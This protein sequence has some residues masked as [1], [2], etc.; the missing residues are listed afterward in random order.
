MGHM[1]LRKW[2]GPALLG[3]MVC[4][5]AP[6]W[7]QEA[8]PET[9]VAE[10]E[11]VATEAKKAVA[12][13]TEAD[14]T[15]EAE[16]QNENE[17]ESPEDTANEANSESG[18]TIDE[19]VS[20][21]LPEPKFIKGHL[22]HPGT[23]EYLSRFDHF[24]LRIGPDLIDTDLYAKVDLGFA[25]Y[26]KAFS[27]SMHL[28]LR[29]L[30][31]DG[32]NLGSLNA[33]LAE[34]L[35]F[36]GL[37]IRRQDWDE[38]PD[39]GKLIRF[40][41]IGRKEERLY[42]SVNTMRPASI[43]HGILMDKYQANSDVDRSM[44]G[45]LF[46]AYNDYAGFQLQMNDVT[47]VNQVIGALVFFK[48]L[49]LISED[50]LA[51]S[52]SIGA[53]YVADF[54]APKCVL[55]NDGSDS[56]C[57]QGQGHTAGRDV[58]GNPQDN[59][60]VYV[61]KDTGRPRVESATVHA[62]GVS[63]EYK[64]AKIGRHVDYKVYSTFHQFLNN[65]GGNGVAAGLLGRLNAGTKWI[66]AFRVRTEYRSFTDGFLPGYFDS[67]YEVTK[68]SF[69]SKSSEHQVTPTKYQ[70]I[71]GDAANGFVPEKFGRSHGYNLEFSWGLFKEARRN[72][73]LAFGF[74][75]S[76]STAPDDTNFYLHL[77][78]PWLG[79]LPILGMQFFATYLRT[80]A[81]S[82]SAVFQSDFVTHEGA[83]ILG[84][85]R[86][87]VLPFLFINAT[88]ARNFRV[89]RQP[90]GPGGNGEYHLATDNVLY[91]DGSASDLISDTLFENVHTMFVD[92]ELGWE[93]TDEEQDAA[94]EQEDLAPEGAVEESTHNQGAQYPSEAMEPNPEIEDAAEPVPAE[95]PIEPSPEPTDE[96]GT[97]ADTE[98]ATQGDP[99]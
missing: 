28:P 36:G 73:R 31:M 98:G 62:L 99:A 25:I 50:E 93:F 44:T 5:V 57:V 37:K 79:Q 80:S 53:E 43:G 24:G 88:Y 46:D 71:F 82:L 22:I 4:W 89:T 1:R 41:T 16:S 26:T 95:A 17:G 75:L 21:P 29:L 18:E 63:A 97:E 54:N 85:L 91:A 65:G 32:S 76:D 23:R 81:A 69:Q 47:M 58:Q 20:E 60:Y 86:L 74:G 55:I 14:S 77:E 30:A 10:L 3:L 45:V 34:R 94:A 90:P 72:K 70:A 19:V 39:Y 61:D 33:T 67:L 12:D 87:E 48:P 8:A 66:N 52:F 15:N 27:L 96:A 9:E 78:V 68:Y 59:T 13:L 83:V 7:A 92:L 56:G 51:R 40:L 11:S 49:S 42:F 6:A 64:F 84:G 38:V 35:Q 2:S